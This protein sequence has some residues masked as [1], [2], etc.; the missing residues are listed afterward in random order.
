MSIFLRCIW[1]GAH[2]SECPGADGAACTMHGP[3]KPKVGL[4]AFWPMSCSVCGRTHLPVGDYRGAPVV[5][6]DEL[7]SH[8]VL[9]VFGDADQ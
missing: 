9:V 1:C 4:R 3:P 2:A 5:V 8:G 7:P 6:C